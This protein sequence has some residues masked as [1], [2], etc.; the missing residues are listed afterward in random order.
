[1]AFSGAGAAGTLVGAAIAE[2]IGG[3]RMLMWTMPI[4]TP[5]V[6]AFLLTDG[7]VSIVAFAA[8]GF[9]LMASFSVTVAMGQAYLP[10]RLALA[11]G[12]LIGFGAIGSAPP[13]LAIFGAIADTAGREAAIWGLAALPLVG[14]VARGLPPAAAAHAP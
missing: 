9:V 2:R 3:R 4:A 5:L 8:A 11:A 6:A 12:L 7:P 14:A 13:G 1:M 10:G